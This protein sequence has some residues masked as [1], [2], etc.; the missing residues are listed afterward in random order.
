MK[1]GIC[2]NNQNI[3]IDKIFDGNLMLFNACDK[4]KA[5]VNHAI[6]YAQEHLGVF[7]GSS[8]MP[9]ENNLSDFVKK[10]TALKKTFTNCEKTKALLEE[11]IFQRYSAY[12]ELELFYDVPRLRVIPNHNLIKAGIS[13]NY[14]PHRDT[15][16]GG[17]MG[18]IN[19]WI[20]VQ[21]VS[22]DA[23][24]YIAPSYFNKAVENSSNNFDLE[25]WDKVHRPAASESINEE[26]RPHPSPY[27]PIEDDAKL[28]IDLGQAY[29]IAFSGAHLHGSSPN[30]T[31]KIRLSIDYRVYLPELEKYEPKNID[32]SASGDYLKYTLQHPKFPI[33]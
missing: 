28:L 20:A 26:N 22:V 33:K 32:S 27:E 21:N 23:T 19:H 8:A 9:L 5:L 31:E 1:L 29:E 6:E 14:Q 16:Y 18:Q 7:F 11:L 4:S 15:W 10:T 12:Q 24:F 13:Y 2:L 30:T 17:G 25:T 3:L